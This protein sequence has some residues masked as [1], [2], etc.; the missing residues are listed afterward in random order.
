VTNFR[1]H[2][3]Q[4]GKNKTSI[5]DAASIQPVTLSHFTTGRDTS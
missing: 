5:K 3:D 4:C 2:K 1:Q